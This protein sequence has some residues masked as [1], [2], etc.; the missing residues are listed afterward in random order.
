MTQVLAERTAVIS[1]ADRARLQRLV[2]VGGLGY[3]YDRDALH[4][5]QAALGRARVVPA[6]DL[7]H[8]VVALDVPIAAVAVD[9]GEVVATRV[10]LPSDASATPGAVSVLTPLGL[11]LLGARVD[12]AVAWAAP[13]GLRRARVVRVDGSG[14]GSD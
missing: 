9:T 3:R 14:A 6:P 11:A 4:A 8:D 10:T 5:L 13:H 12:E 1:D 2:L 7:P